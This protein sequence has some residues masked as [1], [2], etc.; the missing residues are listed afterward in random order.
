MI[1]ERTRSV[2]FIAALA[3]QA[4]QAVMTKVQALIDATPEL[5]G[6]S[7]IVFP[8]ETVCFNCIKQ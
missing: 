5:A 4:Q 1:L 6:Q 8:Y 7:D 2:S 3:P